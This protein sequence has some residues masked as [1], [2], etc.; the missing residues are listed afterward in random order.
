MWVV[1]RLSF[2][3]AA[4]CAVCAVAVPIAALSATDDTER[5]ILADCGQSNLAA[6]IVDSCLERARILD[7][8]D[9]SPQVETLIAKLGRDTAGGPQESGSPRSTADESP[10]A[11]G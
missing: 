3:S 11:E 5:E 1:M 8:T 6:S 10:G 4:L 2:M 7:E 9:P